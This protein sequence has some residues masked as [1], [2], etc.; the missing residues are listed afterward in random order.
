MKFYGTGQDGRP[1]VTYLRTTPHCESS[2]RIE[3]ENSSLFRCEH[4][5]NTE[6]I[7]GIDGYL[8]FRTAWGYTVLA[9]IHDYREKSNKKRPGSWIV[10]WWI[11]QAR[12]NEARNG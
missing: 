2:V 1:A 12:L 4:P 10:D 9:A 7:G 8:T 11:R 3:G 6:D 5:A